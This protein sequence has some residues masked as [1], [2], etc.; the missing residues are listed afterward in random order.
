MTLDHAQIKKFWDRRAQSLDHSNPVATTNLESDQELQK[1]KLRIERQKVLAMME[2]SP[3]ME[4]LDL[5]AGIGTWSIL[6]AERCKHVDIVEYSERMLCIARELAKERSLSN[7]KYILQDVLQYTS[8][9]QYDIIFISG[10]LIYITD[11]KIA[12][13]F[14][15]LR[16]YSKPGTILVLRDSTGVP[17]RYEIV[18]QFSEAA[19]DYYNAIYR[20]RDEYI[21]LF[22]SIGFHLCTDDDVFEKNSPLNKWKETKLRVYKFRKV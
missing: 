3:E 20:T 19:G 6:F 21:E 22:K 4:V 8:D 17:N 10:L 14:E 5:G 13:L 15:N 7:I 1:A 16:G 9:I 12:R 18:N 11:D 2:F